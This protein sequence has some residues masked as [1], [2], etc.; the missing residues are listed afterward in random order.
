MLGASRW[1]M[2]ADETAAV[3]VL[4]DSC[5]TSSNAVTLI[6]HPIAE[7]GWHAMVEAG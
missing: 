6:G 3:K 5:V 1:V 7:N 4:T 2:H